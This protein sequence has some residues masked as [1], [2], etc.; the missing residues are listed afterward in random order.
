MNINISNDV[1]DGNIIYSYDINEKFP[2]FSKLKNQQDLKVYV[3][4]TVNYLFLENSYVLKL[5]I[6]GNN[7]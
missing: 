4:L 6:D 3:T 1:E 5:G 7:R 2:N